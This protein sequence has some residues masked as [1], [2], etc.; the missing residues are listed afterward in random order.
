[1][2]YQMNQL[3][4]RRYDDDKEEIQWEL[5]VSNWDIIQ[6]LK[7]SQLNSQE[8]SLNSVHKEN[9]QV[10]V[11]TIHISIIDLY[12]EADTDLKVD[13]EDE[14]ASQRYHVHVSFS[15]SWA[16]KSQSKKSFSYFKVKTWLSDHYEQTER[17]ESAEVNAL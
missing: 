1:M 4:A 5:S 15:T 12:N 16:D 13:E 7:K 6:K 2:N 14:K 3:H 17:S 9:Y 10:A 8:F 11:N